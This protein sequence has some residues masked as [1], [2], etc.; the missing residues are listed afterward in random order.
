MK[1]RFLSSRSIL[2]R[3]GSCNAVLKTD[4]LKTRFTGT[5]FRL[6]ALDFALFGA[7]A[8][9]RVQVRAHFAIDP[10]R[11]FKHK[12]PGRELI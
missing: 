1:I 7:Y 5:L 3:I 9:S 2:A 4:C 6:L 11:P 10:E 8:S 12:V